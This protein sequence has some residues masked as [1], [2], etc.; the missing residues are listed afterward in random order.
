MRRLLFH[1]H[2]LVWLSRIDGLEISNIFRTD[3]KL[4]DEVLNPC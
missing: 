4:T 1:Q 2:V 3:A